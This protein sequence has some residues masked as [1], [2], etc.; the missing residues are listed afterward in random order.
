[1]CGA[2][3]GSVAARRSK[4]GQRGRRDA[5]EV[6]VKV[7]WWVNPGGVSAVDELSEVEVEVE[8]VDSSD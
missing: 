8:E 2:V 1:V 6:E 4:Q 3:R 7:E 5:I